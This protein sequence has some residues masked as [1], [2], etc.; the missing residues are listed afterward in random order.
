[1]AAW[2]SIEKDDLYDWCM[3]QVVDR[4]LEACKKVGS[5]DPF[6]GIKA[7]IVST[8][9]SRIASCGSNVLSADAGLVPPE[10][11]ALAC[12]RIIVALQGRLSKTDNSDAFALTDDTKTLLRTLEDDLI[13]ASQCELT[14]TKP[15]DEADADDTQ[16]PTVMPSIRARTRRFESPDF[17]ST[18]AIGGYSE[19]FST[20]FPV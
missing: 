16:G 9:R 15:D 20:G 18:D 17:G 14:V 12:L 3:P 11:K 5:N 8:I 10:F 19:G 1:M 7:A 13:A 4:L 2:L 6:D